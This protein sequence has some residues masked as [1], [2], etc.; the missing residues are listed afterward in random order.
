MRVP[1]AHLYTND[2][3]VLLPTATLLKVL[4]IVVVFDA[5]NNSLGGVMCGLGLQRRAAVA[6]LTGY[7]VV[8]MPISLFIVF[9]S[10]RF[11]G[12]TAASV[13]WG[14]VALSMGTSSLLQL[15]VI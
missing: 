14:G 8:G 9:G 5:L 2:K 7:Y 13:L 1:L 6:Q 11:T 3:V 15:K 4:S 10:S 12:A